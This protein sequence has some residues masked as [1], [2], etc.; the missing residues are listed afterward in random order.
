MKLNRPPEWGVEPVPPELRVLGTFDLFVLWS[1][2]GVGLLVLIAGSLLLPFFGLNLWEALA[3]SV[4]GSVLGALMLAV[5]ARP[6]AAAG[7]PTMVSLR[8]ILGTQ[9]SFIPS[10][11]N[12]GQ[13][14][15]WALFE[16]YIMGV[17][18][19]ALT[20]NAAGP[21]TAALFIPAFGAVVALLAWWGPLAVVRTWLEKFAI[22]LVYGST[23]IVAA[24]LLS[25]GVDPDFRAFPA[26]Y[27]GSASLLPALDLVI[28]MPISWWPLVAD[29]NRFARSGRA[30]LVGTAGGYAASNA[31]FY[32]LGAALAVV[33]L[34]GGAAADPIAGIGLLGLGAFPLLVI[35]VDETDNAFANVYSTS[36]SLQNVR[37]R[38]RQLPVVAATTGTAAAGAIA[39][40]AA[41]SSFS[42]T[43]EGFLLLI[44]GAFVPLLGVVAADTLVVSRRGHPAHAYAGAA[45]FLRPGP[46]GA[47]GLGAATYFAFYFA[48]YTGLPAIGASLPAFAVAAAAFIALSRLERASGGAPRQPIQ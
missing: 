15:G 48:T 27:Q 12:A 7:V 23:A 11:V 39:L 37:P 6:G 10:L 35:L 18:A 34:S 30:S 40:V 45:P 29:Y 19:A 31:A 38:S 14:V 21:M 36:V 43:F 2:L 42:L 20:G 46:M 17:A 9:G 26:S 5:A 28:A 33:A 8:P 16:L 4:A 13:L 41:G 32:A 22:W 1:S 24:A 25:R 47:W 3:V 44:G